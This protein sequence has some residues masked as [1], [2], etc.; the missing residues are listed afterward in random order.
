[1]EN[2]AL[3]GVS[4]RDLHWASVFLRASIASLLM[5]AAA[6]KAVNGVS[7][8]IA[9]YSGLFKDSLLPS[10]LVTAHA[11]AIIFVEIALAVWL[12]S[13]YRLSLAWKV[14]IGLLVSLAMGMAFAG[15]YDVAADNYVY[16][17]LGVFGLVSARFDR[18]SFGEEQET[19][20]TPQRGAVAAAGAAE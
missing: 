10:F 16:V 7:G 12:V 4:K 13:G 15:K 9:Y 18:W 19:R 8:T 3:V 20:A 11:S 1:M 5:I 14:T 17:L 2:S 6:N